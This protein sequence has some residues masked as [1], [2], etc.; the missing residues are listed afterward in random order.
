MKSETG[1]DLW[2]G[3]RIPI[4]A[5]AGEPSAG[6][7]MFSIVATDTWSNPEA[8]PDVVVFDLANNC[9]YDG[10]MN[11]RCVR[12][13][14]CLAE[15]VHRQIM[16]PDAADPNWRKILLGKADVNDSPSASIFRATYLE[17]LKIERGKFRVGSIDTF[18]PFQ[19]GAIEWLKCHPDAFGRTENEYKKFSAATL[20]PDLK[21]MLLYIITTDFATRFE[22]TVL[23]FHLKNEWSG[24]RKTGNRVAEGLDII[25]KVA[26][27][28]ATLD[29]KP[30][31]KKKQ[32]PRLPSAITVDPLGKSNIVVNAG[33][34]PVPAL[35]PRVPQFT[36]QAIREYITNP[37]DYDNLKTDERLP[38]ESLSDDQRLMINA[39][40]ARNQAAAAEAETAKLEMVKRAAAMVT[41]GSTAAKPAPIEFH[42]TPISDSESVAKLAEQDSLPLVAGVVRA[43]AQVESQPAVGTSSAVATSSAI[44]TS[45][46]SPITE[47]QSAEIKARWSEVWDSPTAFC[48][49][50]KERFGVDKPKLL[51]ESQ[52]TALILHIVEQV[53]ANT[54]AE[55][56]AMRQEIANEASRNDATTVSTSDAADAES[57][58]AGDPPVSAEVSEFATREQIERIRDLAGKANWAREK[59][60]E[61]LNRRGVNSFRSVTTADAQ[62]LIERLAKTVS[63]FEQQGTPGN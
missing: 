63:E 31:S 4:I 51:S 59:Q 33:G 48:G 30:Q 14:D 36:P 56:K 2:C 15:G 10:S 41:G 27:L 52:A 58:A 5:L 35:P 34:I 21:R 38:D 39:D 13:N 53:A 43:G 1:G 37:P 60:T 62:L 42:D 26:T 20:W 57:A 32:A 61:W 12:I 23:T 50:L 40:I 55:V 22:S 7:T 8:E 25:E 9:N 11:F 54:A 46:D 47:A 3:Q 16:R 6:K 45:S 19:E 28:Y 44:T 18:T 49:F 29:R 17:M 24:E